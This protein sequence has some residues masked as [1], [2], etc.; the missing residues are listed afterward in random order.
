MKT[1]E[2]AGP[3][4]V[5]FYAPLESLRGVAALL[6]ALLH[7]AF[8]NPIYGWSVVRN[9][10]LL[11]DLFFVISGFVISNAYGARLRTGRQALEYLWLRLGRIYPLHLATLLLF[12][13]IGL[14]RLGAVR[15]G[16]QVAPTPDGY[17]GTEFIANVLL[18]HSWM[19]H[20]EL[21][22]NPPSWSIGAEFYAYV[23]FALLA[24]CALS[25]RSRLVAALTISL[26]MFGFLYWWH[27]QGI[28][29]TYR[30]GQLR[31][32]AGFFLGVVAH[33]SVKHFE[34]GAR[35]HPNLLSA[36]TGIALVIVAVVLAVGR[37][38]SLDY[39]FSFAAASMV[40]LIALATPG[41]LADALVARPLVWLGRVS[42]SIY[43]LHFLVLRGV[44]TVAVRVLHLGTIDKGFLHVSPAI[45]LALLL[46]YLAIL[47]PASQ[48]T[49][50]WIED[51][52][53]SAAKSQARR[54]LSN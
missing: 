26:G 10:Y 16:V 40:G 29:V 8:T 35:R 2:V 52:A 3:P 49:F 46:S 15:A 13:C 34:A 42:Y 17:T 19:F 38:G 11:V 50:R 12:S 6:V 20:D 47:L 48:L 53:R 1:P 51:P 36:L 9:G 23:A 25:V 4:P 43:M 41:P 14:I 28:D 39:V 21:S 33:L 27:P 24:L 32:L 44:S 18:V 5:V 37:H 54:W 22:F 45:G 30:G 31:C 7:V